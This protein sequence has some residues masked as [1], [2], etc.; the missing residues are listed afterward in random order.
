MLR[1][2]SL[3]RARAIRNQGRRIYGKKDRALWLRTLSDR[4]TRFRAETLYAELD[5]L[6]ELR[7]QGGLQ[8]RGNVI[9]RSG[10]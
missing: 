3:F 1:L 8:E 7:P 10:R 4:G 6:A 5:L 2:K 9:P